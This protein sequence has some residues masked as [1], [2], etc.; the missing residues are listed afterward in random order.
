MLYKA[1]GVKDVTAEAR[2][3]C[4]TA[5]GKKLSRRWHVFVQDTGVHARQSLKADGVH[6]T[7][8]ECCY[9]SKM[10]FVYRDAHEYCRSDEMHTL[11][12]ELVHAV[13]GQDFRHGPQF[14]MFHLWRV[15]A[16]GDGDYLKNERRLQLIHSV[17]LGRP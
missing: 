6:T 13:M 11:V 14:D 17:L 4:L 5:F 1:L 7:L 16:D 15:A 12:H 10:I 9:G 3:I 2:M 8:G